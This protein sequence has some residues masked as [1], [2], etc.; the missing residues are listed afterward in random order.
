MLVE[1]GLGDNQMELFG[2]FPYV[3]IV[4]HHLLKQL[5]SE[6]VSSRAVEILRLIELSNDDSFD[7]VLFIRRWSSHNFGTRKALHY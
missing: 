3:S 7:Q 2:R 6:V 4:L 1:L 5:P